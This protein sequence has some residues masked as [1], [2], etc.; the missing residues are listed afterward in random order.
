MACHHDVCKL[1]TNGVAVCIVD[2]RR[3]LVLVGREVW[4]KYSGKFN[5]CS[6]GVDNDKDQKCLILTA[7]RELNEEFKLRF[8]HPDEFCKAFSTP[9]TNKLRYL[10]L[11][12]TP[13][14]IAWMNTDRISLDRIRF[15]IRKDMENEKA[16]PCY[17]EMSEVKWVSMDDPSMKPVLSRLAI[18]VMKR[19]RLPT[20]RPIP[21]K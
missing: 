7:M 16:D 1:N 5:I 6:G 19:L 3:R 8:E 11:G 15:H 20:F 2:P 17:K 9:V 21:Q 18:A 4:G 10:V 13:V 14:F 12:T